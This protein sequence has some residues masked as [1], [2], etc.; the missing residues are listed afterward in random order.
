MFKK[1]PQK[2]KKPIESLQ[3]TYRKPEETKISQRN[4]KESQKHINCFTNLGTSQSKISY[5]ESSQCCLDSATRRVTRI[6]RDVLYCY[7]VL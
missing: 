7:D 5:K 6:L 1:N 4:P 3:K 2:P